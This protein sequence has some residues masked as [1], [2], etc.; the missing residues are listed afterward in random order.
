MPPSLTRHQSV[1]LHCVVAVFVVVLQF[2]VQLYVGG[3]SPSLRA[4]LH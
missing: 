4:L 3:M 2:L 1:G